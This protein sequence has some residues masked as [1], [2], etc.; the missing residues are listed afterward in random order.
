L[1]TVGSDLAHCS[2][3]EQFRGQLQNQFTSRFP[4]TY[5]LDFRSQNNKN[6]LVAT[7]NSLNRGHH[8]Q[9]A[10]DGIL[11]RRTGFID[12]AAFT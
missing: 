12:E 10:C 9:L 8:W 4:I 11:V 7:V 6:P 5:R 3:K 2:R 1:S